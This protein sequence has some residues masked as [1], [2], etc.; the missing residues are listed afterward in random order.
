M[1]RQL[2]FGHIHPQTGHWCVAAKMAGFKNIWAYEDNTR[3]LKTLHKNFLK[4]PIYLSSQSLFEADLPIPDVIGGS[5]PCAGMSLANPYAKLEDPRNRETIIFSNAIQKFRP[6]AF[7]MEMVPTFKTSPRYAPLFEEYIKNLKEYK[8]IVRIIDFCMFGTPQRR[9]RFMITGGLEKIMKFPVPTKFC[10]LREA[11]VGLP[12]YTKEEAYAKGLIL[13]VGTG[14]KHKKKLKKPPRIVKLDWDW[15]SPTITGGAGRELEHP[16][17]HRPITINEAKRIMELPDN[18]KLH[19]SQSG[20][21]RQVAEGVPVK[22]L[23]MFLKI[24]YDTLMEDE[25]AGEVKEIS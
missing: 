25:E 11:W 23:S 10:T 14:T 20:L 19:G 22:A 13:G 4:M 18:F 6:K 3:V 21:F 17:D 24:I 5:P 1:V 8:T 9:R 12:K 2:T 15:I 16:S 7:I